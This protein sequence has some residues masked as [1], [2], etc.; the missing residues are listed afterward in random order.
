[1]ATITNLLEQNTI[2]DLNNV[3][4]LAALVPKPHDFDGQLAGDDEAGEPEAPIVLSV[5]ARDLGEFY[6]GSG[7]KKLSLEV[8]LTAN[9]IADGVTSDTLESLTESIEARLPV[10]I[11][12]DTAD[13]VQRL[14]SAK[15]QVKGVMASEET[16]RT[17]EDVLRIRRIQ[18]TVIA[19]KLA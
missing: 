15:L 6:P 7:I 9:S 13:V 19:A 18:R 1:M 4:A 17:E 2:A 10:Q 14:S 16:G 11:H 12:E 3:E 8:V 5:T